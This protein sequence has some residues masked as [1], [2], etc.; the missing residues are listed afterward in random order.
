MPLSGATRGK[1]AETPER[2]RADSESRS[3]MRARVCA[4]SATI[5]RLRC[6]QSPANA[7]VANLRAGGANETHASVRTTTLR[8]V[9]ATLHVARSECAVGPRP[10]DLRSR[11]ARTVSTVLPPRPAPLS[12]R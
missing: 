12:G 5:T 10:R 4:N 7:S 2:P 1:C 3:S 8:T 6:I 9:C 11:M